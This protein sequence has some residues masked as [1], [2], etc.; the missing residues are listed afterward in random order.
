MVRACRAL[1]R[2]KK[3]KKRPEGWPCGN[4]FRAQKMTRRLIFNA[5]AYS[6]CVNSG[7]LKLNVLTYEWKFYRSSLLVW[8]FHHT[9]QFICVENE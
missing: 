1:P 6:S 9:H 7:T 3:K 5:S 8:P 4:E 2:T